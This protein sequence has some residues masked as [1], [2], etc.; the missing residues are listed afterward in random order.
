MGGLLSGPGADAVIKFVMALPAGGRGR[1]TGISGQR[2]PPNER[3]QGAP[4]GVGGAT[5]DTPGFI[6][7][8]GVAALRHRVGIPIASGRRHR[9][10]GKVVQVGEGHGGDGGLHLRDFDVLALARAGAMMQ[11]SGDSQ[12]LGRGHNVVRLGSLDAGVG[13]RI[14]IAPQQGHAGIGHQRAAEADETTVRSTPPIARHADHDEI[15]T[16][17]E[18]MLVVQFIL[19]HHARAKIFHHH[20]ADG[21]Q[22]FEQFLAFGHLEIQRDGAFVAVDLFVTRVAW[23]ASVRVLA[24]FHLDH[25]GAEIRQVAGPI[26]PGPGAAE[27]QNAHALEWESAPCPGYRRRG[28]AAGLGHDLGQDLVLVLPRLWGWTSN[29]QGRGGGAKHRTSTPQLTKGGL[30]E[31]KKEAARVQMFIRRHIGHGRPRGGRN[32]VAL[33]FFRQ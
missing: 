31:V 26:G 18:Q 1:Q 23:L 28:R 20:V 21:D 6:P 3:G 9:A 7:H 22:T 19:S 17:L 13:W 15:R 16:H 10:R 33:Q 24:G 27:I 11:G 25:L 12:R 32:A 4:L 30:R 5:D 29:P 8:T 14:G 2:L